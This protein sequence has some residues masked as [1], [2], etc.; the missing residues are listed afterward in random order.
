MCLYL[1][2]VDKSL[3]MAAKASS[4]SENCY[5]LWTLLSKYFKKNKA[6]FHSS[7]FA[8]TYWLDI[9]SMPKAE[10]S[11]AHLFSD[12]D[13]PWWQAS[14]R[15]QKLAENCQ[16][17][18]DCKLLQYFLKCILGLILCLL[19]LYKALCFNNLRKSRVPLVATALVIICS[20]GF[21]YQLKKYSARYYG[22]G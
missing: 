10:Q 21:N 4:I 1:L 6:T 22:A 15:K 13:C 7:N 11:T 18:Y 3:Y 12:S 17:N 19:L 14:Y 8:I 5:C 16:I 9:F 20:C 2:S